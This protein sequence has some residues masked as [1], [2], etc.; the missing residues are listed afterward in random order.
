M[1]KI[2]DVLN[3]GLLALITYTIL[4][5]YSSLPDRV[6]VHFGIAGNPD[7]WGSKSDLFIFVALVWGLTLL[8]YVFILAVPRLGRNP[9]LLNL[10]HKEEF[11]KLTPEKQAPYWELLREFMAGMAVSVNL[12]FYLII[13]GTLLLIQGNTK[14]LPLRNVFAGLAVLVLVII[15]Y[16]PRMYT[17]PKKLIRGDEL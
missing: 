3:A 2:Y 14:L 7:R 4:S 5:R 9:Q 17:L 8:F 11:L 10:P 1:R 12:I 6:P 13:R 16:L 15:V